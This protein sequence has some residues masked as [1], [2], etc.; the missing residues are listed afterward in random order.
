MRD[1]FLLDVRHCAG[2][3]GEVVR[4]RI[5]AY[6]ICTGGKTGGRRVASYVRLEYHED[7]EK[8]RYH[9]MAF[10][11]HRSLRLLSNPIWMEVCS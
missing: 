5:P 7:L 9:G 2:T 4:F 11:D 10:R 8:A 6:D 1:G 3:A